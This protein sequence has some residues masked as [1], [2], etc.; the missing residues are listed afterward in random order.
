MD[1][2]PTYIDPPPYIFFFIIWIFS[3]MEAC[4]SLDPDWL[5]FSQSSASMQPLQQK[6]SETGL[7]AT[8]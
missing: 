7:I 6:Q 1:H 4:S 3:M 5:N 8:G 2:W